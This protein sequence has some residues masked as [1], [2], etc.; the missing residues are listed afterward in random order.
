L[1]PLLKEQVR[2]RIG[3]EG[4]VLALVMRV[5]VCAKLGVRNDGDLEKLLGMQ[6][7]DGG[8]GTGWVYRYGS[9]GIQ[10]GNR[11]VTTALAINAIKGMRELQAH[12]ESMAGGSE[13]PL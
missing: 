8:W 13:V 9:S 6:G 1:K 5:D 2:E 11:G 7:E 12:T 10:I 3:R 4:D